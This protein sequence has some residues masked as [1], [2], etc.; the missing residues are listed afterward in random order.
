MVK[1]NED[2]KPSEAPAHTSEPRRVTSSALLGS[3]S[4]LI[5]EHDGQTYR[6]RLTAKN[7][8]ILTK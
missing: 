6:L 5:I 8:L 2:T 3:S 1:P 4:E 7:R